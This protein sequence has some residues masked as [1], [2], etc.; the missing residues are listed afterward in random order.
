[1]TTLLLKNADVLVTMDTDRHEIKNGALFVKENVIQAVGTTSEVEVWLAN[2]TTAPPP[3][4]IINARGTVVLPGLDS[5]PH[6]GRNG[7]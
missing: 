2:Q 7:Q 1:M 5:L 6:L 3:D 4:R